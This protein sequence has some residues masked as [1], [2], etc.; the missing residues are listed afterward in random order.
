MKFGRATDQG[1]GLCLVVIRLDLSLEQVRVREFEPI[2]NKRLHTIHGKW[3]RLAKQ[4]AQL[5]GYSGQPNVPGPEGLLKQEASLL[6][7]D[8]QKTHHEFVNP[9]PA[10]P[11]NAAENVN[12]TVTTLECT[13]LPTD[14]A[15]SL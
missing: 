10:T 9:E 4:V 13:T 12:N 15:W 2:F 7:E 14:Q 3:Q 11:C 6:L 5:L 1:H 8:G